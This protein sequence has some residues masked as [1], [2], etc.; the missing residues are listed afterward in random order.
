VI[1]VATSVGFRVAAAE[2]AS[3]EARPQ[4]LVAA[5]VTSADAFVLILGF[6]YGYRMPGGKSGTESEYEAARTAGMP[7]LV[8][9]L[10]EAAPWPVS[11]IATGDEFEA[12]RRFR[13]EVLKQHL[14]SFFT[15]AADLKTKALT[16][17]LRLAEHAPGP[18]SP[19]TSNERA[20]HDQSENLNDVI[21]EI[22]SQLAF[23]IKRA[24]EPNEATAKS[25]VKFNQA[26]R[27][28]GPAAE[29]I[30]SKKVFV[31]MPY[32]QAWSSGVEALISQVCL[33]SGFRPEI[34]K[35]SDGRLIIH[36]IWIGITGSAVVIA[37]LTGANPNV[38]Y[39]VGLS[40]AIGREA[41]LITQTVDVPVDFRGARLIVYE[42]TIPGSH[43]LREELQNRLIA[44][45]DR[46]ES[47]SSGEA[48]ASA[49]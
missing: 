21:L 19:E 3:A 44:I 14:V 48:S 16:A 18:R 7:I 38:A 43:R 13:V 9:I 41:I 29:T 35:Y 36:D 26:A 2:Y 46:I 30:D 6:R 47:S 4:D 39:E 40:D 33:A 1:E 22:R 5:N 23:L 31:I 42:N 49:V 37:D 8:F 45:R 12:I 11:A 28:L 27:F 10:D 17:F 34:A 25:S 15:S 24:L 32:S 20:T